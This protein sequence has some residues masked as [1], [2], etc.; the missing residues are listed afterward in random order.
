[1]EGVAMTAG[2]MT[3]APAHPASRPAPEA[4]DWIG[5]PRFTPGQR[6]SLENDLA[7]FKENHA[8]ARENFRNQATVENEIKMQE[9]CRYLQTFIEVGFRGLNM[10][11]GT[12]KRTTDRLLARQDVVASRKQTL[13]MARASKAPIAARRAA[14]KDYEVAR[15]HLEEFKACYAY[16]FE[17]RDTW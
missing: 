14:R 2:S 4:P 8:L 7:A 12:Y 15:A 17:F 1:M 3:H 9:A 11:L 5:S 16:G 13:E 6:R 10:A